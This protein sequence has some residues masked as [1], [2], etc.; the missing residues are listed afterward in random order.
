MTFTLNS[1]YCIVWNGPFISGE[2]DCRQMGW[3]YMSKKQIILYKN[4]FLE[5]RLSP[6]KVK[7]LLSQVMELND[8]EIFEMQVET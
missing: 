4:T 2:N 3:D 5:S 7:L 6:T 8:Y 1:Y